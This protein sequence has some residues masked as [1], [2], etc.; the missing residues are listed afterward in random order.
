MTQVKFKIKKGDTVVVTTGKYKGVTGEVTKM[1]LDEGKVVVAGV[2]EFTRNAKPSQTNPDGPYKVQKP[3]QISNVALVD[4]D[5]KASKVG[6]RTEDGKKVR[7][8]KK[9][10]EK[11]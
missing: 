11:V 9:S 4:A 5:G 10:G 7:Y 3:I 8:F 1:L 2:N 6:Y